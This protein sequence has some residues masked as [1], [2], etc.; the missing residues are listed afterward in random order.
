MKRERERDMMKERKRGREREREI[1]MVRKRREER[2]RVKESEFFFIQANWF[3]NRNYVYAIHN[4]IS[5]LMDK[6]LVY[7]TV[8]SAIEF[9]IIALSFMTG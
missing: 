6:I 4:E 2:E 5:H 7:R 3:A 9:C 1:E 8:N